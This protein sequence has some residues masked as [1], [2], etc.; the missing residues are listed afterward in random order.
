M[1]GQ[2]RVIGRQAGLLVPEVSIQRL[3]HGRS[4][5]A[6]AAGG[7]QGDAVS[8]GGNCSCISALLCQ[9][10]DRSTLAVSQ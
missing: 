9:G 10:N 2:Q 7:R 5:S 8:A 6:A 1:S 4:Q 3:R